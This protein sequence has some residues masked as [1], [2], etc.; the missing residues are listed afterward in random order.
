M[1]Q[2]LKY[3]LASVLGS[4]VGMFLALFVFF[5]VLVGISSAVISGIADKKDV[6]VEPNSILK[7]DLAYDI[8]E[9]T[10][11]DPFANFNFNTMEL[12]QKL[13]LN[14]ILS[15]LKAAKADDD[16]KGLYMDVSI[17]PSGMAT[18][19]AIR[20]GLIDFK[21][22][23]KFIVTYGEVIGQKAYY[24]ASVS[25][26]IYANPVGYMELKGFSSQIAFLKG[27]MDK[28]GIE[29]QV[30]YDGKYKS[31]TEPFRLTEMSDENKEQVMAL[32]DGFYGHFLTKIASARSIDEAL[33]DSI[34][35]NLLV[36]EPA[37]GL[38]NGL[39]DGVLY[40]DEVLDLLAK[41]VA[42]EKADDIE[43]LSLGKYADKTNKDKDYSVKDKIA[44]LYASG[45][46]VDG[47]GESTSI[48]SITFAEALRD[49]RN[50]ENIK[51]LVLRINS[52]GGSALASDV[53]LREVTLVKEMMPVIISMGD[54]AA[55][56]GYYI[57]CE[58]DT[59]LAEPNTVTGSIGV[60]GIIPN[61]QT[62]FND[63]IGITFDGVQ[64]GKFS[65]MGSVTRPV[66]AEERTIIQA[67]VDSVY[68]TFKSRVAAGRGMELAYVDSI[69]QGRVYTGEQALE[70]GLV[71]ALG[72]ME[73]ALAFAKEKA[74]LETYRISAYPKTE[75]PFAKFLKDLEAEAES[76]Y[77]KY[78][79]GEFYP[80]FQKM[81]E[82]KDMKGIMTKMPYDLVIE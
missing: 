70:L 3:V 39:I 57:A 35:D 32:L 4:M 74:G 23:G 2:F 28:L 81:E 27:M 82:V 38:R 66:T 33:L 59:I 19:E 20:K 14:D 7:L 72:G 50:D 37:D 80:M 44:V 54:V 24:L 53:I 48:G 43:F 63:K 56:G 69:A 60:F 12:D 64:T 52:G 10:E 34:C 61:F 8:P 11:E 67:G 30:F 79:L 6:K 46:I 29:A 49:I 16:I 13:G 42:A 26:E 68:A 40:Y 1:G 58:G 18:L 45:N 5:L 22:S 9:R 47:E 25:D 62:F 71:D 17:L 76:S 78:R 21:T 31:A 51:A 77:L 65:N 73:E 41:K 36:R 55:S 15:S 75:K